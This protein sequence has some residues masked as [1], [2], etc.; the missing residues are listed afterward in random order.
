M[1][2]TVLLAGWVAG[3]AGDL[4]LLSLHAIS[5]TLRYLIIVPRYAG[6]R[7]RVR[8]DLSTGYAWT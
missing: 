6:L 7:Y 1:T 3:S 8:L 5:Y 4:G 2:G